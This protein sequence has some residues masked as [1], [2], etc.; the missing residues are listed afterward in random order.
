MNYTW[1]GGGDC[2]GGSFALASNN[3]R[4]RLISSR[5]LC[6]KETASASAVEAVS[7]AGGEVWLRA[8]PATFSELWTEASPWVWYPR[9]RVYRKSRMASNSLNPSITNSGPDE[10]EAV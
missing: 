4:V 7:A 6:N 3:S 1:G 2:C 5:M 10:P 8:D 9:I